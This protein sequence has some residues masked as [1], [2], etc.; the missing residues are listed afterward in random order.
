MSD[1]NHAAEADI[2]DLV[3][4]FAHIVMATDYAAFADLWTEDAVW[5]IGEPLP[6]VARGREA[7]V[8]MLRRLMNQ[9]G[10]FVQMTH[11][12]VIRVD[13]TR[14]SGLWTVE[15]LGRSADLARSYWNIGVYDDEY[16][17]NS[18]GWRFARRRYRYIWLD[19]SVLPGKSFFPVRPSLPGLVLMPRLPAISSKQS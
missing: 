6:G 14:A 5:E 18:D 4:R 10:V 8:D 7:V 16:I 2:R 1:Q 12:A 3:S 9:F 13:R 11:D 15:E 17:Q 19:D